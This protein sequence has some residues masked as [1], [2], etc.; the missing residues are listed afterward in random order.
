MLPGARFEG[1][2]TTKQAYASRVAIISKDLFFNSLRQ[3][4]DW[5]FCPDIK[6]ILEHMLEYVVAARGKIYFVVCGSSIFFQ[7]LDNL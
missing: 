1:H 5:C 7:H 3:K 2:D 6:K 4:N